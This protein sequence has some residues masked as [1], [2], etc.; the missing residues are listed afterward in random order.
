MS[1]HTDD[2][3]CPLCEEK[4][5]SA[6]PYMQDWFRRLKKKYPTVHCSCAWRDEAAQEKAF[7]DGKTK[8]H[9]PDSKH[10][11]MLDGKPCSLALDIFEIVN[12]K[13]R[14]SWSFYREVNQENTLDNEEI[15]W[16]GMFKS[17]IDG[18]HWEYNGIVKQKENTPDG[19]AGD[20]QK[21]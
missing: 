4:I 6:H 20:T 15:L 21:V 18:P 3:E 9:W 19:T 1:H 14:W 16:G 10:N 12:G 11:F 2:F 17:I 8:A 5:A 7:S 13:E